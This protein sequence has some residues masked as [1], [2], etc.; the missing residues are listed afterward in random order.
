[1]AVPGLAG[2]APGTIVVAALTDAAPLASPPP[3]TLT[4]SFPVAAHSRRRW[5]RP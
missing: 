1:V 3:L 4:V 5:P 2:G